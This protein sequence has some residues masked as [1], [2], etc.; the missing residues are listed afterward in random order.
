MT[1]QN[2]DYVPRY[3]IRAHGSGWEVCDREQTY[4]LPTGHTDNRAVAHFWQSD[5]G[6]VA[7]QGLL[8]ACPSS[9]A[10]RG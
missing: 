8:G 2:A 3:F 5:F 10:S 1:E 6:W 9:S 7:E 4:K